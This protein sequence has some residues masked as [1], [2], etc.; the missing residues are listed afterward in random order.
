[1]VARP[2]SR[3][4][5]VTLMWEQHKRNEA[6]LERNPR[7]RGPLPFIHV[8]GKPLKKASVQSH[9]RKRLEQLPSFGKGNLRMF[10][11]GTHCLRRGG[12]RMWLNLGVGEAYLR[13]L[14]GWRSLAWLVY[15]K[16]DEGL[17]QRAANLRAMHMQRAFA[18]RAHE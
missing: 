6:F 12:A 8:N 11:T 5:F 3:G 7:F 17:K 16:V 10:L 1:M 13:W 18:S 14:G 2:E 15:A 4:D 9:L